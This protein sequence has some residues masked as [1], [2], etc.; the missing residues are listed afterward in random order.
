MNVLTSPTAPIIAEW[1]ELVDR[2]GALTVGHL[3][4]DR[5]RL[6]VGVPK[7]GLRGTQVGAVGDE[8][9]CASGQHTI[10]T[11]SPTTPAMCHARSW[12]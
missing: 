3:D 8:F 9:V 6:Q 2:L 10:S 7:Q 1:V 12:R 5:R 4:V 11:T